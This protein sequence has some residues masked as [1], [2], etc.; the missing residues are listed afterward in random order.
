[1]SCFI[2]SLKRSENGSS[3]FLLW[4]TPLFSRVLERCLVENTRKNLYQT[5]YMQRAYPENEK[6]LE[7]IIAVSNELAKI[8]GYTSSA[9]YI[10]EIRWPKTLK[11]SMNFLILCLKGPIQ[12]RKKELELFLKD[13]P[14]S[15]TL[16]DGKIQ[17]WDVPLVYEWY[18]RKHFQVDLNKNSEYFPLDYTLPALLEVS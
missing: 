1:M 7:Q 4:I 12:K 13:L 5:A 11:G 3:I 14:P 17:P 16:K 8:L 2:N 6:V 15:V 18:K 10:F 9:Q